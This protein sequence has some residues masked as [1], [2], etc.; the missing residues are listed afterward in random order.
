[1]PCFIFG[2]SVIVTGAQSP[3]YLAS[4][5]ERTAGRHTRMRA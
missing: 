4:A 5:I 2:G 1:V 3:E